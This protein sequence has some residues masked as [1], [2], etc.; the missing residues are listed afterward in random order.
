MISFGTTVKPWCHPFL[1]EIIM[2]LKPLTQEIRR[3]FIILP[4]LVGCPLRQKIQALSAYT[5][6]LGNLLCGYSSDS[7]PLCLFIPITI[8]YHFPC[9]VKRGK[10]F[11]LNLSR[12]AYQSTGFKSC[13]QSRSPLSRAWIRAS[14]VAIFVATGML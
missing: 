9:F 8:I 11:F 6:S 13:L 14:A 4:Q 3:E 12:Q 10:E 1:H 7:Q 2:P 5:L